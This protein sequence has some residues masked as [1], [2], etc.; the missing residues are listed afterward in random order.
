MRKWVPTLV[1]LALLAPASALPQT[2]SSKGGVYE[3]LGAVGN[4]LGAAH[5]EHR[6]HAVFARQ[7]GAV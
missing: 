6:R 2:K 5:A 7:R 1:L 4:L 3:Q